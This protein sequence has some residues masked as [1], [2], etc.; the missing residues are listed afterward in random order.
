MNLSSESVPIGSTGFID[1]L[2]KEAPEFQYSYGPAGE[3]SMMTFRVQVQNEKPA[4]IPVWMSRDVHVPDPP[5]IANGVV[6][7]IAT[8]E[9]TRQGGYFPADVRAKA[10]SH[11]T[12]ASTP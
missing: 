11:A 12:S 10:S 1:E 7:T 3:G 5:V 6:F 9:N 8:G 2:S 4:L